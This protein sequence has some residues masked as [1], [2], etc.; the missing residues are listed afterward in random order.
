LC[1]VWLKLSQ[2]RNRKCDNRRTDSRTDDGQRL[3]ENF[4]SCQLKWVLF[5]VSF[6]YNCVTKLSLCF[7]FLL[8]RG[9]F[10]LNIFFH[11][12]Q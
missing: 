5:V 6:V 10:L 4:S 11:A 7:L 3:S 9:V 1:H 8:G 12:S 2:W